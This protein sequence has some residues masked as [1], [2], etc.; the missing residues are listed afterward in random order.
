MQ[1]EQP[2]ISVSTADGVRLHVRR[3]S[4]APERDRG[5]PILLLH[6]LASNGYC[7]RAEGASLADYLAGLGYDCFIPDLRGAGKSG[8]P[9]T[10]WSID[11]YLELDLPALIDATLNE[12][13]AERLC[14]IGHS[15][16]GVLGLMY[17]IEH[18]EAPIA[19]LVTVASTLDYANSRNMYHD[20]R[21]LR[22]LASGW[23]RSVPYAM[24]A[25]ANALV[26][27]V[28]PRLPAE[29]M[30]FFRPNVAPAVS[31]A[32][33]AQGFEAI[34]MPLLDALNTTFDDGGFHRDGG[35]IRY[36][37][38]AGRLRI[39]TLLIAGSRDPHCAARAVEQTAALLTGTR[40]EV[41][42]FGRAYG[43]A[44]D[45]GHFDLLAGQRACDEVWPEIRVFLQPHAHATLEPKATL[46][47]DRDPEVGVA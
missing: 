44:E 36:L 39:P 7:F 8:R 42:L 3:V 18:P 35:R 47:A 43:H 15:L 31:R 1:S 4:P 16:G 29:S 38:A 25:R 21:R 19:R 14:W 26:A 23:L 5:E 33:L 30:N 13:G 27:G 6:G 41:R 17:G 37:E 46:P 28:G 10:P 20:L 9:P 11:E 45:Y 34:P 12:S 40:R 22:P 32:I 2:A 24:L